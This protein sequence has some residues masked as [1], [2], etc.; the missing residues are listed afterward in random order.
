M[1]KLR[2]KVASK[3]REALEETK[4]VDNLALASSL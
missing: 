4:P 3:D 2:E 1:R